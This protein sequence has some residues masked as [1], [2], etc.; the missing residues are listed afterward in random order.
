MAIFVFIFLI[1]FLAYGMLIDHYRRHWNRLPDFT[2]STQTPVT[3]ISVII[4]VR[5]E[6]E[7]II[8]L[9]QSL[10][11]QSYDRSLFEVI[12]VD[13]HSTDDTWNILQ[14]HQTQISIQL[15]HLSDFLPEEKTSIAY[16]KK[17]IEAGISQAKGTL[18]VTTDADC[19]FDIDW[20]KTI[21]AY[22]EESLA[23][24]IAAP[25]YIKYKR[26]LLSIFQSL[27]FLT[28]QGITGGAI[29]SRLH[30]MCNGANFIY[31]K[32]A[33]QEVDGFSGIDNLPSGDDML[34]MQK[35]AKRYPDDVHFLKSRSAIVTTEPVQTWGS[36]FNQ[37]IRWSSKA[38][39][40]K[41]KYIT[42]I[43][44]LVYFFNVCFIVL[45]VFVIFNPYRLFLLLLFILGKVL[46]EFPF[47]NTVA[48][49]FRCSSLMKYFI[50]F[51]PIHILYTI[52]AGWFGKFGSYE[53]K[54]RTVTTS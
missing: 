53:W 22:Y 45:A 33:F 44:F 43:L 19:R 32:K 18:I 3:F 16:K 41:D 35:I 11:S 7:N 8:P 21:A 38:G 13:D 29:G 17:A 49:F 4:P 25:V 39:H 9:L 26:S 10:Q 24:C 27:D 30:T 51:Q 54:G 31:T 36:F 28:L 37:R 47:V 50:L 1:L 2:L 42:P 48:R 52:I 14:Q 46:I 34:L 15:I 40:Y 6:A 23:Q 5:N 12:I 20:L